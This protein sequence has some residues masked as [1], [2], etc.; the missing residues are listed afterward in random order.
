M[1]FV[2]HKAHIKDS[3]GLALLVCFWIMTFPL[4]FTDAH[5]ADM[6]EAYGFNQDAMIDMSMAQFESAAEKFIKAASIIPDYQV[7]D[8]KL[9]YTP[10]FMAAWAFEKDG[11]K[12]KACRYYSQFLRI[13]P[14]EFREASKVDHA[15]DFLKTTC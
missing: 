1:K 6:D 15:G 5:A 3:A 9:L 12:E 7:R 4:G 8:R 11:N 10:T 13:A 2:D 14:P